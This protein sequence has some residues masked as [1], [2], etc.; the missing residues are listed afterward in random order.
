MEG[1]GWVFERIWCARMFASFHSAIAAIR[2]LERRRACGLVMA[3]RRWRRLG[4]EA[5]EDRRMLAAAFAEFLDP[6]PAAGNQFGASV[7]SL[8]TGNVVITSPYDDA[9][10]ADAGAVYLFNGRT[11][12]LISTVTG[13]HADDHVG[14]GGVTAL[15]NGNFVILSPDWDS[16]TVTDASSATWGSG[17]V[18]IHGVISD[19]NSL[20]GSTSGDKLGINPFVVLAVTALSNGN[21]VI[22]SPSWDSGDA[23]DA[24]AVTW[25][26]GTTG[27]SGPISEA[28][29]LVGTGASDQLGKDGVVGL[30][31]GNYVVA[32]SDWNVM[33]GA[34]T[35]GDGTQ[36]VRGPVSVS[37]SLV[38][39]ASGDEIGGTV[40]ALPNGNYLVRS[41]R[42]EERRVGK[43][44]RSRWSPYH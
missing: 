23:T 35:F 22:A 1:W 15:T 9:G 37:N 28:N 10:G 24:G 5:F 26:D 7:V 32:S 13:S 27:V 39:S 30:T 17:T 16:D 43:E 42:S 31:N 41:A 21:Y 6:H 12:E 20:V 14:S 29:S 38:G 11:G 4:L 33:T 19:T 36:G 44:C 34:A 18:G 3:K 40:T 8:A 25:G 2:R